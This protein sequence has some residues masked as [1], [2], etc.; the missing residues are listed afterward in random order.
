MG[1]SSKVRFFLLAILLV[2]NLYSIYMIFISF[3]LIVKT[4]LI[5][6]YFQVRV[7]DIS[8]KVINNETF[9]FIIYNICN[10]IDVKLRILILQSVIYSNG[11]YVWTSSESYFAANFIIL[12]KSIIKAVSFQI[13]ETKL[14]LIADK[15]SVRT[16]VTC[17]VLEPKARRFVMCFYHDSIVK[18]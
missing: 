5:G 6:K 3:N 16:Y 2:L 7:E 17:E 1:H 18:K 12:N 13:P 11:K 15:I 4:F 9:I 14:D 8:L 10:P